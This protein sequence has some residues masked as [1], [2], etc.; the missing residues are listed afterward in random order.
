MN[1]QSKSLRRLTQGAVIAAAYAALTYLS[2]LAN[3]AYGPVQFRFS[4]AL[5][6][7]QKGGKYKLLLA[8]ILI[9]ISCL[10]YCLYP[11]GSG[12]CGARLRVAGAG[13]R[14]SRRGRG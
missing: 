14:R 13:A 12:S 8:A 1:N 11:K 7:M 10:G 4:E 9:R 2:A 3:L 6:R 5:T